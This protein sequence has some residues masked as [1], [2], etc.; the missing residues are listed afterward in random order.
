MRR[1]TTWLNLIALSEEQLPS[2]ESVLAFLREHWPMDPVPELTSQ[3]PGMATF[4][5][6]KA[7]IAYTLIPRPI[8]KGQLEGPCATAWYWPQAAYSLRDHLAHLVVTMVDESPDPL[9]KA[10]RFTQFTAAT[11]HGSESLSVTW[12]PGGLIHEPAT[13]MD[14]AQ[15]M[16][17]DD[18]PLYLWIDFRVEQLRGQH[19]RI[20]TTGLEAFG[21]MELEADEF[22]GDPQQLLESVYNIAHFQLTTPS[23]MKEGDTL[24]QP[25]G[26]SVTIRHMPSL[27]EDDRE[28]ILL[29]FE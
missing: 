24:G 19:W 8:P 29:Q 25:D 20:F 9:D 27:L 13:F 12:G 21:K 15:Q 6:E 28:V 2:H 14:Q 22:F 11:A 26:S 16:A 7:I 18:L 4:A 23:P 3:T 10:I 5:W 17:R 1:K